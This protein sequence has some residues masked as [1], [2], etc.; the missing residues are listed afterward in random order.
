[1]GGTGKDFKS[2]CR[3]YKNYVKNY[4]DTD[5]LMY[6][7]LILILSATNDTMKICELFTK[8]KEWMDS[9]N[10]TINQIEQMNIQMHIENELSQDEQRNIKFQIEYEQIKRQEEANNM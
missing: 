7:S 1:M 9:D 6:S 3:D 4:T 10:I 5:Y 2:K 8:W